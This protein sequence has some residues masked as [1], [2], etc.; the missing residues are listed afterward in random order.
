MER[1]FGYSRILS[2][3]APAPLSTVSVFD[4]GT[5]NLSTIFSDNLATPTPLANP[6]LA[7]A[8]GFFFYYAA[9]ARYDTQHSGTGIVTPYTWGDKLL[10]DLIWVR[11]ARLGL[12]LGGSLLNGL[13]N[14]TVVDVINP[15]DLQLDGDELPDTIEA[16]VTVR[17]FDAATGVIPRVQNITD[18]VTAGTGVSST[19]V[20]NATQSFTVT[21]AAGLK[22]YRLQL[23]PSNNTHPVF[24]Q[25]YLQLYDG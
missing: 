5:A 11:E 23:T 7:D 15:M 17:T 25:G 19:S 1:F 2:T 3:G 8:D 10:Q 20:T 24:G 22:T 6:F 9:N 13:I 16:R 21:L 4:L 18:A 14:A 12:F